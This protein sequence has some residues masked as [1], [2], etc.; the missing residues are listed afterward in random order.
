[1]K[2]PNK[3]ELPQISF[4]HL[5]VIFRHFMNLYKRCTARPYFFLF[6]DTS[7]TSDNHLRLRNNP[8]ERI[9]KLIMTINDKIRHEKL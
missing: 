5:S 7:L 8:L 3:R 2:I 9:E 1:M 6:L 4:D